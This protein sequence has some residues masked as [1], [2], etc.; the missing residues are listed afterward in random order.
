MLIMVIVQVL[1]VV[2]VVKV[3]SG[4]APVSS[5]GLFLLF[6]LSQVLF[7]IKLYLRAVRYGGVAALYKI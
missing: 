2:L 3:L 6:L 1:Y 7:F 5:G 4:Y